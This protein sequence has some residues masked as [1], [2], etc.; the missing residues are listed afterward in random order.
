MKITTVNVSLHEKVGLPNYSSV[1]Y[2]ASITAEL[3]E[4]EDHQAVLKE[5]EG[6]IGK[7]MEVYFREQVVELLENAPV[8]KR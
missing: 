6:E 4:G 1:D 5:L 7:W 2:G 8:N 3:D